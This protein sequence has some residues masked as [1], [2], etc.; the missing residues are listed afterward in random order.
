[1]ADNIE[2]LGLEL[3]ISKLQK[4]IRDAD[5]SIDRLN[6]SLNSLHTGLTKA[7]GRMSKGQQ[8]FS[9][10][11]SAA[12]LAGQAVVTMAAAS[13]AALA[14]LSVQI[15]KTGSQFESSMAKVRAISG[16]TASEFAA[17][18]AQA[19]KMG[20]TT[21][22]SA[23]ESASALEFLSMAGFTATQSIEA[24]PGVLD[25]AASSGIDLGQAADIASNA[26]TAMRLQIDDLG[27]VNDV[28][29]ATI[30]STNTNM[31]E[32]N[33]AFKYSASTAAATGTSIEQLSAL[34]GL[35]ANAGIKGSQAGTSLAFGMSTLLNPSKGVKKVLGELNV[36]V[37]QDLVTTF[38]QL[39]AAGATSAQIME[40]FGE[41]AGRSILALQGAGGAQGLANLTQQLQNS[42]GKAEELAKIMNDTTE[43][44]FKRLG[45]VIES[46]QLDIFEESFSDLKDIVNLLSDGISN[47]K[48]Q[49]I[50]MAQSLRQ[51]A[52]FALGM[53]NQTS[54]LT[55][56]LEFMNDVVKAGA[57]GVLFLRTAFN[58]VYESVK[59]V[60]KGMGHFAATIDNVLSRN[61]TAAVNAA[62]SGWKEL[63]N[64]IKEVSIDVDDFNRELEELWSR[65]LPNLEKKTVSNSEAA[66]KYNK[67]V[68]TQFDNNSKASD[69]IK[70]LSDSTKNASEKMEENQRA[71]ED[72]NRKASDLNN[73][74]S[75]S[76]NLADQVA[77]AYDYQSEALGRLGTKA[78]Q[79][80]LQVERLQSLTSSVSQTGRFVDSGLV[81]QTF[82][83]T[84]GGGSS[85]GS[86]SSF[87][88]TSTTAVVSSLNN[89]IQDLARK[90]G[91][92]VDLATSVQDY[93]N[94]SESIDFRIAATQDKIYRNLEDLS[95]LAEGD[96]EQ[97]LALSQEL[98]ENYKNL[99]RLQENLSR[100]SQNSIRSQLGLVD[101]I[102]DQINQISTDDLVPVDKLDTIQDRFNSI[103]SELDSIDFSQIT[104]TDQGLIQAFQQTA[105]SYLQAAQEVY[106]SGDP[107]QVVKSTVLAEF[108]NLAE[109]LASSVSST[110]FSVNVDTSP[111]A[112]LNAAISN[113]GNT[114][115]S[116]D[117]S[118]K[119]LS[120]QL[121]TLS[122][123][124]NN[125]NT[126][127][128]TTP[129]KFQ[130]LALALLDSKTQATG[131]ATDIQALVSQL[132]NLGTNSS[133]VS[134]DT[135][136]LSQGLKGTENP[137]TATAANMRI[138]ALNL[139]QIASE[140]GSAIG[141]GGTSGGTGSGSGFIDPISSGDVAN[142]ITKSFVRYQNASQGS[143]GVIKA[144]Y[145]D[146]SS[147]TAFS[148]ANTKV[149]VNDSATAAFAG[150][151][152]D[153]GTKFTRA[154]FYRNGGEG[155]RNYIYDN[156]I[157][158]AA[159][160][161]S[162]FYKGTLDTGSGGNL[163]S[164]GGF[165][166]I[167]HPHEAVIR[168]EHVP[169]VRAFMDQAGLSRSYSSGRSGSYES[170]TMNALPPISGSNKELQNI[171]ELL[172][173]Q[174]NLLVQMMRQ[175]NRPVQ[176]TV[177]ASQIVTQADRYKELTA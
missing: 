53:N 62:R 45:S 135:E 174:N 170:G 13:G 66:A 107:Y 24:L 31:V 165:A 128:G 63:G 176:A 159:P 126:V 149:V 77:R 136:A 46:I 67:Q 157:V 86:G 60:S 48:D 18:E 106:K 151:I 148:G 84:S 172:L 16:A 102:V 91:Q 139:Q 154:Y 124:T 150:L 169:A 56:S 61:F 167:L 59:S 114:A 41:R 110:D 111:L 94:Q 162:S 118:V 3:D 1:M 70:D 160:I 75:E 23:S 26:L 144:I 156:A 80:A 28:F 33:E 47:N 90:Q 44:A 123:S 137:F 117:P 72:L 125:L 177:E 22:F 85:F 166:A 51:A 119:A 74:Q 10:F 92:F 39:E 98:F 83:V 130:A 7:D 69:S 89:R 161:S 122:S 152:N 15:I 120:S 40:I 6:K 112:K 76:V 21:K 57:S 141:T 104:Q 35:L 173:T 12:K 116:V 134:A 121:W 17:L 14:G 132:A 138:F 29:A 82:S 54:N 37:G 81:G 58:V 32:M 79:T 2:Q 9:K 140:I 103:A 108:E 20:E 115:G 30:T 19:R 171:V 36:E 153:S 158:A 146:G 163:D 78:E 96:L 68:Q 87:A 55:E 8:A 127:A 175:N 168:R 113:M 131:G 105:Q 143:Y 11:S 52:E 34:I 64:G 145:S 65:Q 155:E 95:Y 50:L 129:S 25:L 42:A 5:A 71:I 88:P 43:G 142:G 4:G 133:A 49:F 100:D 147:E 27:R 101:S 73:T 109:N 164:R 93:L 97:R 38:N 99:D